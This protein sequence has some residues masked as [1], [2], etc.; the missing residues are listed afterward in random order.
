MRGVT[1][2]RKG[3]EITLSPSDLT[4]TLLPLKKPPNNV[5]FLPDKSTF[6]APAATIAVLMECFDEA[7][8]V[9]G[10]TGTSLLIIASIAAILIISS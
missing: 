8:S 10:S 5:A 1:T 7:E 9:T 6:L 3:C 4:R 2:L